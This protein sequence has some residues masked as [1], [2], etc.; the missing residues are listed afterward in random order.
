MLVVSRNP[1]SL[2]ERAGE[3][4]ARGRGYIKSQYTNEAAIEHTD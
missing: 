3:S 1:L 4:E 2:R